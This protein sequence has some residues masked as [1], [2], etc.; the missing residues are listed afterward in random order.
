MSDSR[1]GV[2]RKTFFAASLCALAVVVAA[3]RRSAGQ[4]HCV[5]DIR[6]AAPDGS[7]C[8]GSDGPP[9]S[10]QP[11]AGAQQVGNAV[12]S[13]IG[14][15]IGAA[16]V[17]ALPP[18]PPA[19]VIPRST[20]DEDLNDG[21]TTGVQ[22]AQDIINGFSPGKSTAPAAGAPRTQF[23]PPVENQVA[24]GGGVDTYSGTTSFS[25]MD[26]TL[27]EGSPA[28]FGAPAFNSG[29]KT[30][31]PWG[32]GWSNDNDQYVVLDSNSATWAQS[33][34]QRLKFVAAKSSAARAPA[35]AP[36]A[37]VRETMTATETD[38]NGLPTTLVERDRDGTQ[39]TFM[40]YESPTILRLSLLTDRN[41]N[42]VTYGRSKGLLTQVKDVHGRFMKLTYENGRVTALS[43]SGGR[44]TRY[45][46]DEKGRKTSETGPQGTLRYAYDA[47]NRLIRIT[48][49]NGSSHVYAYDP[50]G[51]VTSESD[52]GGVNLRAYAYGKTETVVTDAL[53]RR[54]TY[55]NGS[56]PAA[57]LT[58]QIRDAGGGVTTFEYDDD[59]NLR[60][61]TDALGRSTAYSYDRDGNM[62][63]LT[64]AAGD[65]AAMTYE[66]AYGFPSSATDFLGRTTRLEYDEAG[67]MTKATDPL[68]HATSL[69]Y[70]S[71]GHM[72]LAV[73]PL[74]SKV[75]YSYNAS[76]GAPASITDPLGQT[77]KL[78]TDAL[79]RVTSD[80]D[81][82]NNVSRYDYDAAGDLTRATDALGRATNFAYAAGRKKR[83]L[84]SVED[85]NGH[86][87]RFGYDRFGR[88]T[89]VTDALSRVKTA[90]YDAVGRPVKTVN[91][92]G[93]TISYFYDSM[94][95]LIRKQLPEGVIRYTYDSVGNMLTAN[96]YNGSKLSLTYDA[97]NRVTQAVQTLPS[98]YAA[99]I[100]YGYDADG[101]RV[102]MTTPWGRFSY[103]YDELNRLTRVTN[104]QNM[105]F[106]FEYD[107]GGRR[108]RTTAPN[109]V[110]T[111]YSYDDADRLLRVTATNKSGVVVSSAAYT[112]DAAG[113]RLTM[114]DAAGT[115]VYTYD[116]AYQLTR[117]QHPPG[118]R[119]KN[120]TEN[121]RYDLAGNRLADATISG[122]VYDAGNELVSSR[123]ATYKY[124]ADGNQVA[125]TDAGGK[126]T[127]LSFDSQNELIEA[128][129]PGG[130]RWTYQYDSMM[131]RI[132]KSPG[133][134]DGREIRYVY[135]GPNILATLDKED[136]PISVFTFGLNADEPLLAHKT[137]GTDLN[138]SLD[139]TGVR[140]I[141][142][143]AGNV[144]ERY[145]YEAYGRPLIQNGNGDHRDASSVDNAF[146][147][148]AREYDEETGLYYNRLRYYDPSAGAFKTADPLGTSAGTNLYAYGSGNPLKYSDPQGTNVVLVQYPWYAW[149][150]YAVFVGNNKTGY[151][152]FGLEPKGVLAAGYSVLTA[153]DISGYVLES[154][155]KYY[156]AVNSQNPFVQ[157]LVPTVV[158]EAQQD[159]TADDALIARLK[160]QVN[161]PQ[162]YNAWTRNCQQW[163]GPYFYERRPSSP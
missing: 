39:R 67:N 116:G 26:M 156:P 92:R 21:T 110:K 162:T 49:P 29:S 58:T 102:S 71:L 117:A 12:G 99:T 19:P 87:T 126:A 69:S 53:D 31:G 144:V 114:T 36:P 134:A 143:E 75:E 44:T 140:A 72:T 83:L 14:S 147:F 20:P 7:F 2:R 8:Q 10:A 9:P 27:H 97:L 80:D 139:E 148:A 51:R 18:L 155:S 84:S 1:S 123:G 94:D 124:D 129:S 65:R 70:D 103:G 146:M 32:L 101:N 120:A 88:L 64:N 78:A 37:G 115:H 55:V 56:G 46:Y 149:N 76:N 125:K 90:S 34:G 77:T 61:E 138:Y 40:T 60:G 24:C 113:N 130:P 135:D 68:G 15:A 42:T 57:G 63:A 85:A 28:L 22:S 133:A 81:A 151:S 86:A 132:A 5:S 119:L 98:G 59:A 79:S 163:A 35:Y 91:A 25:G 152:G 127:T 112:Y 160:Q 30:P 43:D 54:T 11:S 159:K 128:R 105:V 82:L 41:G 142:N 153:N 96:S 23:P 122:Y 74:D 95:R 73:S 145:E 104:P 62:I 108:T 136:N 100:V 111:V 157:S 154:D 48:Y 66:P 131:R 161:T 4:A 3:P 50:K 118:T 47:D 89:S 52:D 107:A 109:G 13:V 141:S 38:E 93:Q 137:S 16:L 17:P 45:A 150:H 33:S 121:F 106:A 6:N 158:G